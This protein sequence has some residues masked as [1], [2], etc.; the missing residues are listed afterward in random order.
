VTHGAHDGKWKHPVRTVILIGVAVVALVTGP[1]GTALAAAGPAT[2][3]TATGATC[4]SGVTRT[5]P[6]QYQPLA[7]GGLNANLYGI[8]TATGQV[9]E[10]L[11]PDGVT[12]SIGLAHVVGIGD[13]PLGYPEIAYG[14]NL[15]DAP[16]GAVGPGLDLPVPA[17]AL[18]ADP[19]WSSVQ[20]DTG[21]TVPG[22]LGVDLA[23]D[24]WV[25]RHPVPGRRPTAGDLEIMLWLDHSPTMTPAHGAGA[26]GSVTSTAIVDGIPTQTRWDESVGVGGTGAPLVSFVLDP[27][28]SS[29]TFAVQLSQFVD[30][31]IGRFEPPLARS[32]QLMGVEFGSE[33][34]QPPTPR[35]SWHWTVGSLD[36]CTGAAAVP[37]VA[38]TDGGTAPSSPVRGIT[39]VP[40]RGGVLVSWDPTIPAPGESA[41]SFTVVAS[42]GQRAT[43]PPDAT[44]LQMSHLTPGVPV[45]VT[46]EAD[47][48][49]AAG[50]PCMG[51]TVVP[52]ARITAPIGR[53]S[54]STPESPRVLELPVLAL[55]LLAALMIRVRVRGRRS[56]SR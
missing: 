16:V 28:Q 52:A 21:T 32:G 10:C 5:S 23:Y 27:P 56:G 18:G 17:S 26:F 19:L 20:Y 36:L 43:A 38:A 50:L 48:P 2:A 41:P 47:E 1:Q 8:A 29:G 46:V 34:R 7:L 53:P 54:S 15:T 49:S 55:I 45:T 3:T 35:I 6:H 11:T 37:V 40:D 25:E 44:S 42:D 31:A 12:T 13:G 33:F 9:D 30:Q 4:V 51:A 39:A 24:L 14:D 22:S